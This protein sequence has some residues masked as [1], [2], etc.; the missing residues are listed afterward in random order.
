MSVEV[1][2]PA[3][4]LGFMSFLATIDATVKGFD[5]DVVFKA[6]KRKGYILTT[7]CC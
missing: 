7:A 2:V 1:D 5:T 4:S 3:V 6:G